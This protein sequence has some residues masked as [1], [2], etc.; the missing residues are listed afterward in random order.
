MT[1]FGLK[2]MSELRSGSEL[3]E[4]AVMAEERGF[5]F[6][7]ISDHIHPWLPDHDHSPFAWSVLGAVAARTNRIGLITGVTCPTIRYHPVIIAQAA[8]TVAA[9]S[10]GRFTLGLG[11]GERLNEH[12][13]G[14]EFP[15]VDLRHAMLGEAIT[16]MNELWTGEF[17]THRGT[18]FDADHVKIYEHLGQAIDVVLA[19]SGP[20]SL[21]LAKE[22]GCVGIMATEPDADLVSAWADRGG[23]TDST[24]TEV[25]LAWES[26]KKQGIETARRFRFGMAGWDMAS[27]LPNPAHFA[28]ATQFISDDDVDEAIPNG[29]DPEP[30]VTAIREYHD[31]GFRKIAVVPVGD[32]VV[33]TLDF[34]ESEVRPNLDVAD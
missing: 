6:V 32:D 16:I 33:G 4:H 7:S 30:Y 5:D 28:A 20:A 25:P 10:G 24:W 22:T 27:E 11:A 31:A 15:S 26:T 34:F 9:M 12:V 1:S 29:P 13:T 19:V 23:S 17:V 14:A 2:L 18:F 21:D 8:A 3:V